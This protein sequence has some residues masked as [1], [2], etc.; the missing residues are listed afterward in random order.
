[1]G[2]LTSFLTYGLLIETNYQRKIASP[3]LTTFIVFY[4]A[5]QISHLFGAIYGT[6][7]DTLFIISHRDRDLQKNQF[8]EHADEVSDPSLPL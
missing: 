3:I 4:F 6:C 7:I 1:M 5:F 8:G 2:F